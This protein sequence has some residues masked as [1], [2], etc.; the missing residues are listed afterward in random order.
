MKRIEKLMEAMK[1]VVP[2]I[3]EEKLVNL[4]VDKCEDCMLNEYCNQYF[5]VMENG[6]YVR[7]EDG[8]L[9]VSDMSCEEIVTKWL[10]EN[11]D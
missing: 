7:Y 9:M 6:E 5:Y 3:T 10:N 1:P 8:E 4:F 2:A 11:V